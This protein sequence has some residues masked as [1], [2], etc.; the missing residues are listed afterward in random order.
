M[1]TKKWLIY[2]GLQVSEI[3]GF[4]FIPYYYA[5]LFIWLFNLKHEPILMKWAAGIVFLG[6]SL[7]ILIIL[8]CILKHF[9]PDFI[10]YNKE[11][12]DKIYGRFSR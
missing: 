1:N 7:S 8:Y 9:I 4:I 6:M 2:I 10:K 12:T 3:G 11:L 5:Q